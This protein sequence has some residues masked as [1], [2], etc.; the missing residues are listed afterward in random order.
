MV[1]STPQS[2]SQSQP[3]S[4]EEEAV[5]RNT[6]CIYFLAS[7][8]T[9]KKGNECEYRHSDVARVNPRD[10]YFWLH[11]NCLNPKCGFRHLPLDGLL[12]TQGPTSIGSSAPVFQTV[13]ASVPHVSNASAKP[14]VTCIFFQK[15]YCVKGDWCPFLHMPNSSSNKP[16][17]VPVT[18]PPADK[19]VLS[20]PPD[21]PVTEPPANVTKSANDPA[22]ANSSLHRNESAIS[23]RAATQTSGVTDVDMY[24]NSAPVSNGHPH[25]LN[26]NSKDN[27]DIS[28]EPSPGFDVLVD[29]DLRNS[30]YCPG[31][32]RF[33]LSRSRDARN[34]YDTGL[35]NEEMHLGR[36]V[37]YDSY[38]HPR[39]RGRYGY[40]RR[41]RGHHVEY[42]RHDATDRVD[43][44]DLRHRLAKHKK[45]PNGLKSVIS[46]ENAQ[47]EITIS[48][49]L[50]GRIGLPKRS[51]SPINRHRGRLF[52][53]GRSDEGF[54]NGSYAAAEDSFYF[55]GPI[56][57]SELKNRKNVEISKKSI[58]DQQSLSKRKRTHQKI[59]NDL[60]FE[61]PKPLEEILKRKRGGTSK[62][63]PNGQGLE[64]G[65]IQQEIK[66]VAASNEIYKSTATAPKGEAEDVSKAEED[67]ALDGVDQQLQEEGYEPREGEWDYEQ[68]GGEDYDMY[69]GDN[70]DYVD[71]EDDDDFAKKMGV[72]CS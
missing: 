62:D 55:A 71:E 59:E 50:I 5:K 27:D 26:T 23:M 64:K 32:D 44:L 41:S 31:D 29:D 24:S 60:S 33:G 57:F 7:P 51:P 12:G 17:L 22:V 42:E 10:C 52:I 49:R 16:L 69:E 9:C 35:L 11:G 3:I 58:T 46:N 28:R 34:E 21:K 18:A 38:D 47:R 68:A 61:G 70:R 39:P 67:G 56:S 15:G 45:K 25:P 30:D 54:N 1:V 14:G 53:R 43:E 72:V 48:S 2:E 63:E 40:E 19:N 4:A 6:D 65:E 36:P 8:L 13:V 20:G 66:D 37:S